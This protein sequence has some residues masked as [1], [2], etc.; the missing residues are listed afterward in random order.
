MFKNIITLTQENA[1]EQR[2]YTTE[3]VEYYSEC[4]TLENSKESINN[5]IWQAIELDGLTGYVDVVYEIEEN[6]EYVEGEEF[7]IFIDRV[8]TKFGVPSKYI[9]WGNKTPHLFEVDREKSSYHVVDLS[10]EE[11]GLTDT[12]MSYGKNDEVLTWD[13]LS[14]IEQEQAKEQYLSIRENKEQRG[15]D[16]V[17]EE[18]PEPMDW[19]GVKECSFIRDDKGYIDVLI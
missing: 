19:R 6:G 11:N 13:D 17:T 9:K 15:R 4:D 14:L 18:Y 10:D 8:V 7:E 16:E 2:V 5:I 3:G 12:L 1:G